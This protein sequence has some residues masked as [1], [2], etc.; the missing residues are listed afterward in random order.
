MELISHQGMGTMGR[1]PQKKQQQQQQQEQQQLVIPNQ[2]ICRR[3]MLHE[4][5]LTF[6][7]YMR[8]LPQT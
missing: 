1:G 3:L 2:G 8:I 4:S 6:L 5:S 7:L